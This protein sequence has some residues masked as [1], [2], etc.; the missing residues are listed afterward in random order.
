MMYGSTNQEKLFIFFFNAGMTEAG[1]AG[2]TANIQHESGCLPNNLENS[3]EKSPSINMND[4]QYTQAVDNGTYKNFTTDRAG[5]GI[6]QWTASSRKEELY[7]DLKGKGLSIADLEGQA[8]FALLEMKR[9]AT[10]WNLLTTTTDVQ[11]AAAQFM[12]RFEKPADQSV[13]NQNKRGATAKE[14]YNKYHLDDKIYPII[15]HLVDI[16]LMNSPDYWKK[17]Y[18]QI[19]YLPE[20]FMQVDGSVLVAGTRATSVA[21]G[22]DKL[23]AAGIINSPAYWKGQTGNV[24]ELLKALGGAV[25]AS[26]KPNN[27]TSAVMTGDQLRQLVV[28][29]MQSWIGG[30]YGSKEHQEILQIYNSYRPLAR[31]YAMK[32]NDAYCAATVSAAWIKA[33]IAE[34]T[35]TECGVGKFIS[36]AQSKGI[37]EENDAYVPKP[38][39]ALVYD[40]DDNGIGDNVGSGD[41]I[42][43]VAS[44]TGTT[45][46]TAEG[47]MSGGVIG[48][49]T[50]QVNGRY[51]RGYIVPDYDAIAK[52]LGKVPEVQGSTWRTYTVVKGDSLWAIANRLLGN[53]AR[54][55]EIVAINGIV[56]NLIHPG[57]VL[58]IPNS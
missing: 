29:I 11:K 50:M 20:L 37:W 33:G 58:R 28:S 54:Y 32:A 31:G 2:V 23:V 40:W 18:R 13:A 41:H 51:I 42:C 46:K 16:K 6:C 5:Y 7:K 3:K 36:I 48:S 34:Y 47:N 35:G 57:D 27:D 39:D 44:I 21:A 30:K 17:S 19:Q 26:V 9:D 56:N 8:K 24:G 14:I 22:V 4:V 12:L 53:G 43:I 15:Q 38:G 49:K 55:T 25:E 52:K 1:A 10:L 45:F